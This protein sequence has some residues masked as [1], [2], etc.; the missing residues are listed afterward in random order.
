MRWQDSLEILSRPLNLSLIKYQRSSKESGLGTIMIE[1][2]TLTKER[3]LDSLKTSYNSKD[4]DPQPWHLSIDFSI[5]MIEM[6]MD[7]SQSMRWL[8]L[9]R[10]SSRFN[11]QIPAH[12]GKE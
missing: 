1:V 2:A 3:L 5:S 12:L 7:L 8:L 10:N 11:L 9:L 6:A 4:K